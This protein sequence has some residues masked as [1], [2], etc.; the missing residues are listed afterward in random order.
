MRDGPS[1]GEEGREK[2]GTPQRREERREAHRR[3]GRIEGW[4]LEREGKGFR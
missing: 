1:V 2:G 3:G 4:V